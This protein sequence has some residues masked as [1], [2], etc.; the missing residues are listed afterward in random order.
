MQV[1][2]YSGF[3]KRLLLVLNAQM[4]QKWKSIKI[5]LGNS[6]ENIEPEFQRT[7]ILVFRCVDLQPNS[8]KIRMFVEHASFSRKTPFDFLVAYT[9]SEPIL[10]KLKLFLHVGADEI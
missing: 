7:F 4:A 10:R 3:L 8:S 6:L 2:V 9:H 5:P 1:N